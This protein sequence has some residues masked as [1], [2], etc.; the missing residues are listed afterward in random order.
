MIKS[1]LTFKYSDNIGSKQI[2][3]WNFLVIHILKYLRY[4]SIL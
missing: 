3:F 2:N 4:F 1:I